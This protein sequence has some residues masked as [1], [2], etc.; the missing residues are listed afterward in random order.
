[1]KEARE[2]RFNQRW[3]TVDG[4]KRDQRGGKPE[5]RIRKTK[6]D[7][8]GRGCPATHE[9]NPVAGK[10]VDISGTAIARCR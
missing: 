10:I 2:K 6:Y 4:G 8:A 3:L 1:M 9:P 7:E 5:E